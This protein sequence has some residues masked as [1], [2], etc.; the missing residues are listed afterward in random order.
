MR[1][2]NIITPERV[3]HRWFDCFNNP[4]SRYHKKPIEKK[5][6]TK[7]IE[8]KE[9]T[10]RVNATEYNEFLKSKKLIGKKCKA[11]VNKI[12]VNAIQ[13]SEDQSTSTSEDNTSGNSE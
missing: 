1:E 13:M 10:F 8:D 6:E 2:K 4:K 3:F 7:S 11:T 12:K 9:K 5:A